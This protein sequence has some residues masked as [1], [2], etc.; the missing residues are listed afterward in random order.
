MPNML[1][2]PT[3]RLRVRGKTA[4]DLDQVEALRGQDLATEAAFSVREA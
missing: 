3:L 2:A 4:R 1:P